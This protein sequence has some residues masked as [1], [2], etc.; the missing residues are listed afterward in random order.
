MKNKIILLLM[1]NMLRGF[2]AKIYNFNIKLVLQILIVQLFNLMLF[3][4]INVNYGR[5]RLALAKFG[6]LTW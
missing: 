4:F 1:K 2:G 6:G 3:L 5:Q